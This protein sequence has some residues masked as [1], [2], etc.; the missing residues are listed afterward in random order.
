MSKASSDSPCSLCAGD[1]QGFLL[2]FSFSQGG[3]EPIL[4]T[5]KVLIALSYNI[6]ARVLS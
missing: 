2:L 4:M 5:G 3:G 1:C 6:V